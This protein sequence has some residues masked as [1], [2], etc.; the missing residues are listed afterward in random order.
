ML[1]VPRVAPELAD[2]IRWFAVREEFLLLSLSPL[3]HQMPSAP[4]RFVQAV[5]VCQGPK[6]SI[7]RN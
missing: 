1:P 6:Y 4:E 5:K 3:E 2:G 7:S